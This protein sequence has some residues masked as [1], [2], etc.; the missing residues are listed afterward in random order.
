MKVAL[1][2]SMV[3]FDAWNWTVGVTL[4]AGET[5]GA[6]QTTIPTGADGVIRVVGFA[7]DAD[8]IYFVPSSDNSTVVA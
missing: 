7:V 1:S 6:L 8:T 2:G 5:A 4:Y 3:R